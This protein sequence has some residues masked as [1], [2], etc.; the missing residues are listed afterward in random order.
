MVVT[1]ARDTAGRAPAVVREAA[2]RGRRRPGLWVAGAGLVVLAGLAAAALVGAAGNRVPVL[3]VARPVHVGQVLAAA[4]LLVARV[5]ADEALRPVPAADR[6]KVVGKV[7]AVELRSGSLLTADAVTGT[8]VPGR[9]EQVV[10]VAVR[11]GQWPARGL[12]PGDHVLVVATPGDSTSAGPV[13]AGGAGVVGGPVSARVA[14]V[15][16]VGADGAVTVDLAVDERL[17]ARVAEWGS[18]GR[19]ALVLTPAD[20]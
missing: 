15:G 2:V 1:A 6:D 12:S 17:G 8:P 20:G 16:P 19:V 11:A 10:G 3:A 18:T 14:E 5:A 4:D 7:A 13:A 9:G